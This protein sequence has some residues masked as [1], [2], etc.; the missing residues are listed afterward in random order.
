MAFQANFREFPPEDGTDQPC[1]YIV[2]VGGPLAEIFVINFGKLG[3]VNP[4]STKHCRFQ[5][6]VLSNL[7]GNFLLQGMVVQNGVVNNHDVAAG[8]VSDSIE[9]VGRFPSKR[10]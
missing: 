4:K 7:P 3:G 5:S 1:G 2:Q 9:I 6:I 10:H 8:I